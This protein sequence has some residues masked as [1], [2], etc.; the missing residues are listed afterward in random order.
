MSGTNP[1][2]TPAVP[3]APSTAANS[4]TASTTQAQNARQQARE[5]ALSKVLHWLFFGVIFAVMPIIAGLLINASRLGSL[6]FWSLIGRGELLIV[7]AGLAAAAAGQIFT[8]KSSRRHLMSSFLAF[9]NIVIACLSSIVYANISAGLQEGDEINDGFVGVLS[10][11]FFG[12]T[13]VT[14]GSSALIVELEDL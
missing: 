2:P 13:L 5:A 9:S 12:I 1:A 7:T 10:L 6:G 3:P 11:V 8:K 14:A 4:S